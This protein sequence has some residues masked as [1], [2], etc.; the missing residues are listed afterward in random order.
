V[1]WLTRFSKE[2]GSDLE[3]AGNQRREY[4][5]ESDEFD[6]EEEEDE[7]FSDDSQIDESDVVVLGTGNFTTFLETNTYVLVEFY[8]PWCGHCQALMPEWAQ[9]ASELKGVVPLAKV[10]ATQHDELGSKYGV[11]GYPT[12]L[13][14]IDG[15]NKPYKGLRTRSVVSKYFLFSQLFDSHVCMCQALSQSQPLSNPWKIWTPDVFWM[16]LEWL[17]WMAMHLTS[18]SGQDAGS[19]NFLQVPLVW[20]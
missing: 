11:Q 15:V 1:F 8:A 6:E 13:F 19:P 18:R 16:F 4:S 9:A 10:D 17:K 5:D 2:K 14:F 20:A 3:S 12:I 7:D